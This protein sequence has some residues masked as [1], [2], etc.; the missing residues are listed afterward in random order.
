MRR[1]FLGDGFEPL[2]LDFIEYY[3]RFE[4]Q[5]PPMWL[6]I[7]LRY[8]DQEDIPKD[9]MEYLFSSLQE[10]SRFWRFMNKVAEHSKPGFWHSFFPEILRLL[11][12]FGL[13]VP[14]DGAMIELMKEI[15][16]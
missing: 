9:V 2:E 7:I 16:K 6:R 11:K 1:W 14:K 8:F 4:D 13:K 12:K 15:V 5:T 10:K 3:T